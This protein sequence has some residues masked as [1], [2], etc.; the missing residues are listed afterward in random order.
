M[1][2]NTAVGNSLGLIFAF[3]LNSNAQITPVVKNTTKD[4]QRQCIGYITQWDAWKGTDNGIPKSAYNHLN[5][6]Y[7]QY[8]I[9]NFSF[10]GVAK[11][12]SLHS[13][14][15]RN[16]QIYQ[17]GVDQDP[18]KLVNDDIYSSFDLFFLKGDVQQ[19]WTID[20]Y[21]TGL[22]YVPDGSGWKN[23]I[24]G[25]SGAAFPINEIKQS[26]AFTSLFSIAHSKG[27]KVMASIG[28]WS[29]CKHFGDVAAD[30]TKRKKFTDDCKKLMAM[31][32]DGIDIDWEYP[33]RS[34]MNFTGKPADFTNF[35][36][37]MEEIR[38]TIGTS[39]LLTGCFSAVVK[40]NEFDWNRLNSSMDYFNMMTYDFNG[41]WSNIAGHNAPLFDYPNAEYQGFSLDACLDSLKVRG[42]NLKKVNLGGAFYGRGVICENASALNAKTV[43]VSKTVQPDGPILTCADFDNFKL[44]VW[45]GTPNYSYIVTNTGSWTEYWDNNAMVPYKTNGKYFL[46][47]DNVKSTGMKAQ[48]IKDND[49]AGIIIWQVY[50]DLMNMNSGVI[51]KGKF[52][53]CPNT[54]SPLINEINEVFAGKIIPLST[55]ETNNDLASTLV[56]PNPSSG[57]IH[58]NLSDNIQKNDILIYNTIGQEVYKTAVETDLATIDLSHLNKGIYL[59]R[60]ANKEGARN[61]K[62]I[63]E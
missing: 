16:K 20:N 49:L 50:G 4:H 8:T 23:T 46:S 60:I 12:G 2:K 48:Y 15:L 39:K 57:M 44:D 13:A 51:Q 18:G 52:P 22:G 26:P 17:A 11:D 3:V 31:G 61:A 54:T 32:F 5:I 43:K 58:V 28:G 19:F 41:G 9:L 63:L 56:Y 6:D 1:K 38:S 42:V 7:S 37:L 47:Y 21:L 53:F 62:I 10:F 59:V 14:D 33:G 40:A 34:G 45:D 27:V 24:T 29:M 30:A 35:A 25:E 36:I 55:H